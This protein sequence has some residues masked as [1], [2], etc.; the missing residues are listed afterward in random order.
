M[1]IHGFNK[2]TLLDYPGIVAA[3]LFTGACNFRCPFC[4]NS[5]LVL[6]PSSQPLIQEEEI[7]SH[8]RKRKGITEGV[9]ITGGEPTLQADLREFI[10][11]LKDLGLKVKLDTN[12][13]RP[14]ILRRLLEENLLDYVAMDVKSSAEGY[15]RAA[16]VKTDVGRI[17]ESIA[18][19]VTGNIDYEFRTT[20]V[21][22]LHTVTEMEGIAELI[23]GAKKY[24]L[25]QY[26]DRDSVICPGFSA[27]SGE[28]MEAF[29]PIFEGKVGQVSVRGVD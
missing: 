21:R 26:V 23:L 22:E 1:Q 17:K 3:T 10:I 29:L 19:L 15:E 12:G 11:K 18:L 9:C 24:F 25:Q 5:D 27:Y 20:V 13:Y 14:E 8:L 16:G 2:T 6:D 7:L 28:E 4:Q